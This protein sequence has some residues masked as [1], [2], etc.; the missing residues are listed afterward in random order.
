MTPSL[1]PCDFLLRIIHGTGQIIPF[2]T[3]VLFS[4][5]SSKRALCR[6]PKEFFLLLTSLQAKE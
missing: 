2:V 4:G 3:A 5:L 1:Y 6:V